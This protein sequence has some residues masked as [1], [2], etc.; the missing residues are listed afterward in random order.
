M[1][2]RSRRLFALIL[3]LGVVVVWTIA[4]AGMRG[5]TYSSD[6]HRISFTRPD[7]SWEL[8]EN[9]AQT[10]AVALFS[11]GQGRVIALLSHRVLAPSDVIT[12]PGNLRDRWPQLVSDISAMTSP[13]ESGISIYDADYNASDDGVTFE[14]NY[15]SQSRSMGG[16]VRNWVTGLMVRDSG[17][18]QHIYTLRCAAY[19][20][21]FGSWESQFERIAPTLTFDGQRQVPFYTAAPIPWWWYALGA[22]VLIVVLM[23]VF[24]KKESEVVIPSR[25]HPEPKPQAATLL[26]PTSE[27]GDGAVPNVPDRTLVAADLSGADAEQTDDIPDLMYREA[28]AEGQTYNESPAP[29]GFWKCECGRMNAADEE[30]CVR[31]N[32]DRVRA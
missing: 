4:H 30:Y 13:D 24:R 17:D 32:A 3:A 16:K 26:S 22:L 20:G 21:I 1:S 2:Y 15:S 7:G 27:T 12:S 5:N 8:R 29:E 28:A 31:C 11:N 6:Q 19:D 18:R 23:I 14:L 25:P 10:N 9:P